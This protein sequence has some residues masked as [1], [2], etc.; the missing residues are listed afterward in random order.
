[1]KRCFFQQRYWTKK[2]F[3]NLIEKQ[4]NTKYR[5]F[6]VRK[7]KISGL[8]VFYDG[9]TVIKP[10]EPFMVFLGKLKEEFDPESD[11]DMSLNICNSS[12]CDN[13]W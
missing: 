9:D 5:Q 1:M 13:L 6:K 10:L 3:K 12:F 2:T 11:W 7:S 8:G 4:N